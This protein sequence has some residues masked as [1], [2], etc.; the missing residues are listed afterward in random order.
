MIR[1]NLDVFFQKVCEKIKKLE[2]KIKNTTI[3]YGDVKKDENLKKIHFNAPNIY[4][5]ETKIPILEKN[6]KGLVTLPNALLLDLWQDFITKDYKET[7][8]KD[9][10]MKLDISYSH[11]YS[12]KPVNFNREIVFTKIVSSEVRYDS[13]NIFKYETYVFPKE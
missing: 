10:T 3:L 2:E 13:K 6:D 5:E 4:S 11:S 9:Y 8:M 1:K 12:E 7:E